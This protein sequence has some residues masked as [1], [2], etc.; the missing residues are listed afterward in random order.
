MKKLTDESQDILGHPVSDKND[1]ST[2]KKLVAAVKSIRQQKINCHPFPGWLQFSKEKMGQIA[3]SECRRRFFET[4]TFWGGFLSQLSN[5][6]FWLTDC[7]CWDRRA[8]PKQDVILQLRDS[9]FSP[10]KQDVVGVNEF[11]LILCLSKPVVVSLLESIQFRLLDELFFYLDLSTLYRYLFN[12]KP[13][14]IIM[15]SPIQLKSRFFFVFL[16]SFPQ[17]TANLLYYSSKIQC[18]K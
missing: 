5:F 3:F 6:L 15:E 2:S 7:F 1:Q 9:L 10:L 13:I 17:K 12:E 18:R 14:N 16:N 11:P 4:T 8:W